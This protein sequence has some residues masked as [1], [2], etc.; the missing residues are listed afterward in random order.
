MATLNRNSIICLDL[1]T[2]SK[3]KDTTE[4]LQIAAVAIHPR[5][6]EFI[7]EFSAYAKPLEPEKIEDEA[8]R[9]NHIDRDFILQQAHPKQVWNDFVKFVERH[10]F[11]KSS[12]TSPIIAGYNIR[13]FDLPIISRYCQKYGPWKD[14]RQQL[15][16][17]FQQLDVL[18]MIFL[19]TE[20]SDIIE[21]RKLDTI[22]KWMGLKTEG[23]HNA[24][25]DTKDTA[26]IL[27]KFIKMF[28]QQAPKI[29]FENSFSSEV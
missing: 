8:L 22:R 20:N 6:L 1:E 24:I 7:D 17:D 27:I 29:K 19:F 10:N 16:S 14:N 2:G 9:I 21:N 12:W 23:S 26:K 4:I 15:F 28:R 11:K 25:K 3:F 18:D 5:N 13:G